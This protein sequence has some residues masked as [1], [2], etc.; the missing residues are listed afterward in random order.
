M[1]KIV[2]DVLGGADLEKIYTTGGGFFALADISS[3]SGILSNGCNF[4]WY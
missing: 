4:Q 3:L 1:E 2:T